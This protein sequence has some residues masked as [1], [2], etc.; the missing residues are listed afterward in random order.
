MLVS[1][2]CENVDL[3]LGIKNMFE[4][5]GLINLQDS[6]FSFLNRSVPIFPKE[7]I[8]LKPKKQKL[9]KIEAQ[10]SDKISGLAI[11]K[12]LHKPTQNVIMLKVKFNRNAAILNIMNN[13]L[14]VLILNPKEALGILDL[15]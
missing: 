6:C 1:E 4:L 13:G 12:L 9:V 8:I 15:R 3:V 14:E 5:E 7:T 10:F 11:V 2:I